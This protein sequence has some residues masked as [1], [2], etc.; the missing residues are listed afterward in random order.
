[1]GQSSS[2]ASAPSRP[3]VPP[4]S[5]VSSTN[6]PSRIE[7]SRSA[8]AAIRASWV[9]MTSVCPASCR[10]LEKPQHVQGGGAV[11]VAGRLV[12]EHDHRLVAQR[13]GDRDPL[14]LPAGQ[15]RG[16]EAAPG[17][18]ARPAPA[19]RSAR[20]RAA[21]GERP[22]SS[23]GSSTFST[24]VSS[25]I[26]WKAWKTKPTVAPPHPGQRLLAQLVDAAP[27][28]PH[29]PAGGPV[30][31]AE[32][33][34]QRRLPAA[35]RPHHRHRLA[36]ADVEVDPVDGAHQPRSLAVLLAQPAGAQHR[37]VSGVAGRSLMIR[38][39]GRSSSARTPP[40]SAGPPA[41]AARCPPA[42]APRPSRS[43]SAIAARCASR[44]RRSS[45]RRC[46]STMVIGSASPAA[47]AATSL[48]WNSARSGFG[49]PISA[50]HSATRCCPAGSA[51]TP[52]GPAGPPRR[53]TARH[54]TSPA[55]S[56]RVSVT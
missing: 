32:Q 46:V 2:P 48:R 36:W 53:P 56:S 35:A 21:R 16:Q 13:P 40:A 11:E 1:M 6:A 25:S 39:F 5:L 19:A 31:P 24:A 28:Q 20:R 52:C 51:R 34:Q 12:G 30:Q 17:R 47:A 41:A 3:V 9:T 49:Q 4:V 29:L 15:R 14:P 18:R 26:R 50:S 33:V 54:A 7:I 45:S 10:L 55:F 22:A 42:A 43:G 37:H 27:G 23:A 44:S 8:V 38:S